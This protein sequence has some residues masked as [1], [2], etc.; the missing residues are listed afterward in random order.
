MAKTIKPLTPTTIKTKAKPKEKEFSLADGNGLYL[1]VTPKGTRSW[2][3]NYIHPITNKRKNIGLGKFPDITL[4]S[5]REKARSMRQQVA[6]GIDP[7]T[8]RDNEA[9]AE[10]LAIET[11]LLSVAK[12]WI[13]VKKHSVTD[14]Y[15][16]D[17]WRSLELHIFPNLGQ[18]PISEILAPTVITQLRPLEKRGVLETVKRVCQRLNEIMDYAVNSGKIQ[19]NPL[20]NIR[21][22][23]K[24]PKVEHMKTIRPNELPLLMKSMSEINI[25]LV[26]RCAF[27]FQLH[28]LIRPSECAGA[29]WSEIDLNNRLWVIP[30]EKMKMKRD[31]KIPLS[32]AALQLLEFMK[33]ISSDLKYVF[34]SDINK[35]KH[36]NSQSVNA[37]LKR[38]GMTGKLVSH[39]LRSIG[40]TALNEQSFNRDAIELSLAHVDKNAIRAIYNNAEYLEER[41]EIMA[42]WSEFVINSSEGCYTIAK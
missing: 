30:K 31:H 17:I 37:V 29:E 39:G 8:Y 36:I 6:E 10:Q 9:V 34:P 27:E 32:D 33:P 18:L 4:A 19:A 35:N 14:D 1:R 23:F 13:D 22:V 40:S 16:T 12:E 25:K 28:T 15:A 41:R 5:A 21:Q 24:K 26:T 3:F 11:T 7:K 38:S 20:T 2:I 42:W